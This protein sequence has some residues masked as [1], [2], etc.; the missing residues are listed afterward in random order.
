MISD[1]YRKV[2]SFSYNVK[3]VAVLMR[4]LPNPSKNLVESMFI[5]GLTDEAPLEFI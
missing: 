4:A 1:W 3:P 5:A 2:N